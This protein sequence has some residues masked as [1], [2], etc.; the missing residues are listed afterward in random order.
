MDGSETGLFVEIKKRMKIEIQEYQSIPT[1]GQALEFSFISTGPK[2]AVKKIVQFIQTPNPEIYNL[3]FGN[4][5]PDGTLDDRV[6]NDNKDSNKVLATV[7]T[8]VHKFTSRYPA[9]A[10]FFAGTTKERTR[11]YRMAI[12]NRFVESNADFEI[13]GLNVDGLD[14]DVEPFLKDKNYFAFLVKRK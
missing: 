2:G 12:A 8:A 6:R 4:F 1:S 3:A 14:Y 10:V 13:F 9:R 11:L 7:A 5:L